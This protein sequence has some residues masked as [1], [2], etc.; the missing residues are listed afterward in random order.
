MVRMRVILTAGS[1]LFLAACGT[2]DDGPDAKF[3]DLYV[4]LKLVS[5]ALDNDL[6]KAAEM[7]RVVLAQHGM[8]SAEFH[9]HYMQLAG[10]P[11]AWRPFQERVVAR[12]EALQ[13]EQQGEPNGR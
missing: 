12:I 4:D 7:R 10:N 2:E 8:T 3:V 5:L 11:D 1:L 6:E 13:Q 9:E